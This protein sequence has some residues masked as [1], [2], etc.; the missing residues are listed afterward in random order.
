MIDKSHP[1]FSDLD[2]R[3]RRDHIAQIA[4]EYKAP[5][6]VPDVHYIKEEHAVWRD[7]M[8][9]IKPVRALHYVCLLSCWK[10]P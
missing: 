2:Y 6:T 9:R 10:T 8:K 7:I 5:A 4:L 1:G 3:S